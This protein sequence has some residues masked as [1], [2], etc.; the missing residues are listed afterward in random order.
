MTNK[1]HIRGNPTLTV[2]KAPFPHCNSQ[3]LHAPNTCVHCDDYPELQSEREAGKTPFT[4][5]ESNGWHGNIA[6]SPS[7][8][9]G[10][11]I[12]PGDFVIARERVDAD[13]LGPNRV[14]AKVREVKDTYLVLD[15]FPWGPTFEFR[16]WQFDRVER[17]QG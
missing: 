10:P 8:T 4:P 6:I 2:K 16:H 12:N 1:I 15:L 3:V 5:A 9:F 13:N 7:T 14:Y 17:I 11:R